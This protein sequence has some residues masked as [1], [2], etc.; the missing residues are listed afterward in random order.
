MYYISMHVE[1]SLN[2]LSVNDQIY[3]VEIQSNQTLEMELNFSPNEVASYDFDLP[4][5]INRT[6]LNS[7][8]D[9]AID[10]YNFSQLNSALSPYYEKM[11]ESEQMMREK[12]PMTRKSNGSRVT[13]A[14]HQFLKRRVT[15]VG[16]RHAL[17][18]SNSTI[19]FKIPIRYFENLKE[20]GFY[21]AKVVT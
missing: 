19:N 13:T 12:T 16:L 9:Q 18:L 7:Q 1:K 11:T 8:S 5:F 6:L 2:A 20:G 4:I 10:Q 14:Q 21:E 15:A 17:H 3:E